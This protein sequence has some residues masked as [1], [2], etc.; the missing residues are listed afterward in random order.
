M[1]EFSDA[2]SVIELLAM[3]GAEESETLSDITHVIHM[4]VDG[5]G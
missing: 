4:N 3:Y 5:K 1:G 2:G